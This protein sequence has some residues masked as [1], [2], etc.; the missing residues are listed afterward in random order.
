MVHILIHLLLRRAGPVEKTLGVVANYCPFCHT[1]RAFRLKRINQKQPLSSGDGKLIGYYIDCATCGARFDTDPLIYENYESGK[2]GAHN[3]QALIQGTHPHLLQ[4][5]A[6]RFAF[7]EQ[8]MTAPGSI[9]PESR[10]QHMLEY[11]QWIE[12]SVKSCFSS[13]LHFDRL[14]GSCLFATLAASAALFA[15]S[16]TT[17]DRTRLGNEAA[18]ASVFVL[19]AGLFL[20]L[21][22]VLLGP[23]R[24]FRKKLLPRLARGLAPLHPG[25]AELDALLTKC[26]NNHWFVGRK[27][28]AGRLE[29]EIARVPAD[30]SQAHVFA[31]RAALSSPSPAQQEQAA[32][33]NERALRIVRTL[34]GVEPLLENYYSRG[35]QFDTPATLGCLGTLAAVGAVI[36]V[37]LM[38]FANSPWQDR[39]M[40]LA[41]LVL[42]LGIIYTAIQ[43]R[44]APARF[45]QKKAL[46]KLV[47]SLRPLAPTDA[48]ITRALQKCKMAG[49]TIGRK[50]KPEALMAAL[51]TIPAE[52]VQ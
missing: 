7:E 6:S 26:R 24:L 25:R 11:F 47:E 12:P 8:L 46:P 37:A 10:A 51:K 21:V 31:L 20:T 2:A 39:L 33:V 30:P 36:V 14:S 27:T 19:V 40:L 17:W 4:A 44:R 28:K 45:T 3:I 32:A 34:R 13:S 43:V 35:T 1:A 16:V 18:A 5:Y 48:E 41:G 42:T 50:I 9:P 22:L 23:G 15:A 38:A 29:M 49:M 52:R